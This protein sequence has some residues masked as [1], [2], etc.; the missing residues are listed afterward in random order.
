VPV[1]ADVPCFVAAI[2]D[3]IATMLAFEAGARGGVWS[4][5]AAR[6]GGHSWSAVFDRYDVYAALLGD[7]ASAAPGAPGR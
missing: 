6:T 7:P 1:A 4:H 5:F 3:A 2:A